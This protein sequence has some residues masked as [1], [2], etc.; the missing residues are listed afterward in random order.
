MWPF[1]WFPLDSVHRR[2]FCGSGRTILIYHKMKPPS[3]TKSS[4]AVKLDDGKGRNIMKPRTRSC[5]SASRFIGVFSINPL[6]SFLENKMQALAHGIRSKE[7]YSKII[8][9]AERHFCFTY[10]RTTFIQISNSRRIFFWGLFIVFQI[11]A[12]CIKSF[13]WNF[14]ELYL[15][16]EIQ[17]CLK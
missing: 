6:H 11:A 10:T 7:S 17:C 16:T 8:N 13:C 3:L 4:L 12:K 15:V 2:C 1:L 9:F 5:T 14:Q